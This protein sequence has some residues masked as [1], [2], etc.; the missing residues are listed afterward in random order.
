MNPQ[1]PQSESLSVLPRSIYRAPVLD[2][3]PSLL[4]TVLV[5]TSAAGILSGRI[6]EVEAYHQDDPASHSFAGRTAR[7]GVMFG[8][9]GHAYVYLIYGMHFCF[10]VVCE[11]EGVGSAVLVRAVEP[12]FGLETIR[13]RR[14]AARTTFGLTNGPAK[15]AQAFGISKERDNGKDLTSGDLVI[16]RDAAWRPE[17]H[18]IETSARIGITKAAEKPWR[19]YLAGNSFV[20]R[21]SAP[22]RSR[23]RFR[24][25]R[26]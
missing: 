20:S 13:D 3:A 10:N 6:V 16:C 23:S 14:P 8:Q 1:H 22:R 4:G 18:S 5:R 21:Q 17:V 12:I 2:V 26:E 25:S 9:P 15:L 11:D 24:S 7:T 19:Y